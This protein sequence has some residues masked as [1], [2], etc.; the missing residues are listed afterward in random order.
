MQNNDVKHMDLVS[1][2]V[3]VYNVEQYLHECVDSILAQTY[4]NIEVILVDDGSPD[5]CPQICDE[6]KK[7]DSRIRVI[8][9][10]NGGLSDAR[11]AGICAANGEYI[12]FCD[13]DD[14]LSPHFVHT[15]MDIAEKNCIIS[16]ESVLLDR[17]I[18]TI[19]SHYHKKESLSIYTSTEYLISLL[20]RNNDPSCCNKLFHKTI[21]GE[22]R[23]DVGKTNEDV[24]F[25]F[26]IIKDPIIVKH[27][28]LGLYKYRVNPNSIT[29]TFNESSLNY[30]YNGRYLYNLCANCKQLAEYAS[31]YYITCAFD[32]CASINR[33]GLYNKQPFREVM[34]EA[35]AFLICH[36]NCLVDNHE[37][38]YLFLIL[39]T[40]YYWTKSHI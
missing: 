27:T 35:S 32:I 22:A 26:K 20:K 24:L 29:H 39:H 14:I 25:L 31:I 10:A 30:Y 18:E 36:L 23:F 38:N 21:I 9:K 6:Y 8:H 34:R 17:N 13:S 1:I 5:R 2:I 4:K 11:N 3:P 7:I 40:L 15:L 37:H 19:I 28:N 33:F 16:C 12:C